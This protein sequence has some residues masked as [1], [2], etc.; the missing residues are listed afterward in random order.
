[1]TTIEVS[2]EGEFCGPISMGT[3]AVTRALMTHLELSLGEAVAI[4]D[5]CV[6]DGE[7]VRLVS[8]SRAQADALLAVWRALP[9][10]SRIHAHIAE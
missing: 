6:F 8:P 7:R 5:R 4:V 9:A 2:I 1:M 3:A 10:A